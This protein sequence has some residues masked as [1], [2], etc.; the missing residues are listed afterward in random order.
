MKCTDASATAEHNVNIGKS[1]SHTQR[2]SLSSCKVERAIQGKKKNKQLHWLNEQRTKGKF[3]S[4]SLWRKIVRTKQ[5]GKQHLCSIGLGQSYCISRCN[6]LP[7]AKWGTCLILKEDFKWPNRQSSPLNLY[8]FTLKNNHGISDSFRIWQTPCKRSH[9]TNTKHPRLVKLSATQPFSV[10]MKTTQAGAIIHS[11]LRQDK[12]LP[13]TW[14][15]SFR[16]L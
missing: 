4:I 14:A 7:V 11:L 15:L 10:S 12:K 9:S 13:S 16:Q 1:W 6:L 5:P 2:A 3:F 8:V